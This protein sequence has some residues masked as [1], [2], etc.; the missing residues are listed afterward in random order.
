MNRKEWYQNGKSHRDGDKPAVIYGDG[1]EYYYRNG[2]QYVP[3]NNEKYSQELLNEVN[4]FTFLDGDITF[5]FQEADFIST[6]GWAKEFAL[7]HSYFFDPSFKT[8]NKNSSNFVKFLYYSEVK[9]ECQK[10]KWNKYVV[11]VFSDKS[12]LAISIGNSEYGCWKL[13]RLVFSQQNNI[14]KAWFLS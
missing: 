9:G 12:I 5:K 13:G 4:E 2:E 8:I 1:K 10:F 14:T 11:A 6:H 7:S 3:Q